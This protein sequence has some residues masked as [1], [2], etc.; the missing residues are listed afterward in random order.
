[1][2]AIVVSIEGPDLCGKSTIA[3]LLV[4]ALRR[5]NKDILFKRTSIP[6]TLTTG[7]FTKVLRNSADPVSSEVFALA[8]AT[9]HL[10]QYQAVIKPL[11]ESK[12]KYV[13]IQ[14]RSLLTYYL[15]HGII[16]GTEIKWMREINKFNKN[17]PDITIVLR[18]TFDEL[19]KRSMLEKKDFD[20]FEIGKHLE[21]EVKAYNNLSEEFMKEFNVVYV[22]ANEDPEIVTEK[23][24]KI[25]Q[26][27]IEETFKK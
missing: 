27:K 18:V 11:K 16:G 23:C 4:E 24:A 17:I 21:E 20:K 5:K 25:V 22:D 1:M 15:Y 19:Q 2:P 14:E 26:K 8:Y 9:D 13:V 12:E 7:F 6:S 3:N 10:H